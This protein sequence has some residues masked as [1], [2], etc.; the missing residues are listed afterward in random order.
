MSGAIVSTAF[1][2]TS[3]A[4]HAGFG[5]GVGALG[6]DV[7]GADVASPP[8]FTIGVPTGPGVYT[9]CDAPFVE[10]SGGRCGGRTGGRTV[11]VRFTGVCGCTCGF[12]VGVGTGF[13]FTKLRMT[14]GWTSGSFAEIGGE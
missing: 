9:T 14:S 3:G 6:A 2:G 7:A 5:V 8:S 1:A 12:G 10:T 13:G 4:L 11:C